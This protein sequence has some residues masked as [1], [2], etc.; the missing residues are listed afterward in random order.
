MGQ[1][2]VAAA[3]MSTGKNRSGTCRNEKRNA[4][5]TKKESTMAEPPSP[6]EI[7]Y[8]SAALNAR[9]LEWANNPPELLAEH[10]KINGPVIRTR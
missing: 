4:H 3:V 2:S 10:R 6:P 8:T 9:E 7:E 5:L 1:R